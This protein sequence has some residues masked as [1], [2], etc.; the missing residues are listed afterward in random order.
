MKTRLDDFR[1]MSRE[2]RSGLLNTNPDLP[3]RAGRSIQVALALYLLPVLLVV[4]AVGG[5]GMLVLGI[6]RTLIGSARE[7]LA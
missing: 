5:A 6:G 2:R 3:G 4:L 7:P 1:I